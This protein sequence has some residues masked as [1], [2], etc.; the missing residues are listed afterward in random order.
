M[1]GR[2]KHTV[3]SNWGH[4]FNALKFSFGYMLLIL[5]VNFCSFEDGTEQGKGENLQIL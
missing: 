4:Y 2:S 1:P 3:I 5:S